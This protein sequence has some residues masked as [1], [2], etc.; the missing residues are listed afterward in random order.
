M[1][2]VVLFVHCDLQY[3]LLNDNNKGNILCAYFVDKLFLM[4]NY[5]FAQHFKFYSIYPYMISKNYN[6][7][8]LGNNLSKAPKMY[9]TS[10]NI[11]RM[12]ISVISFCLIVILV[13]NG[14]MTLNSFFV[15][16]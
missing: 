10:E 12:I 9:I 6:R 7:G 3:I 2:I 1:K 15:W 14:E 16:F 11:S 8:S 5:L 13:Y 4:H